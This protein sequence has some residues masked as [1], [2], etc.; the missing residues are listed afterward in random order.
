MFEQGK[1]QALMTIDD[2]LEYYDINSI[3]SEQIKLSSDEKLTEED[4]KK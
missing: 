1:S 2:D 3:T 4:A